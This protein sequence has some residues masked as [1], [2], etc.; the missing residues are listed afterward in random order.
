MSIDYEK[1]NKYLTLVRDAEI[2][3]SSHEE[4][5]DSEKL[6]EF[7][8]I[9]SVLEQNI[10]IAKSDSRK[11]S[12]GIV[13]AVKAGKSSFLNAC[14][15]AGEDYLPKAATPMTAA[16]TRITYSETPKAI[17]HFYTKEDWETIERHSFLYDEVLDADYNA[18]CQH[19]Y[20]QNMQ[21]SQCGKVTCSQ[22]MSKQEYEVGFK[23][24]SENQRGAKELTK[25]VQDS[26]LLEKLGTTDEIEGNIIQKLNDY[27]GANGHYTPIVSY[28]ELQVDNPYVKDFEI[29]D[30]PGL[31]D[32][33]V[34]RGIRT[35][36]FLRSCDVVLL[37]SPCSQFM[38]SRT[39]TLMASSLPSAGVRE[40]LVVGSKLDSGILN[41]N[42][43]DFAVAY[44][45]S[46]ASYKS[47]F[48]KNLE[49]AKNIGK[50]IDILGKM[51]AE[52]VLFASSSC[53][54]I[55][56]KMKASVALDDNEHTVYD[57]LHKRFSNF[58]DDYFA[59]LGGIKKVKEKLNE[60]LSRKK[61]IIEGKNSDLLDNARINHLR[62]LEKILQET[63]SSRTK[64]ETTSA[65]ELKHKSS[66]IRDIIDSSRDKLIHIFDNAV[67]KCDEKVQQILPQLTAE[68]G[69]HKRL[70]VK[71]TTRDE[72]KTENVGLFGWK[73]EIVHFTVTDNIADISSVVE[74]I[75]MYSAKCHS[76]V[77]SEFKNIFNKEKFAQDIKN[78]VLKAF[79][80]SN[81]EF[82]E[83]DILLPLQNVLD[84][85][86]IH[87]IT[88]DYTPYI[89]EIETRFKTGYAKN[90][91]IPQLT[92]LQS[93][94][95]N[96]IEVDISTQLLHELKEI[97][98]TL[99][100]Q[101]VFFA[102][103][104]ENEFCSEL[105]K[106]QGQVEEREKYIKEYLKFAETIKDLKVKM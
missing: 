106:L 4:L 85:I 53:F 17:I 62:V 60:V 37:L 34:S 9:T 92:I 105:E 63:V 87:H 56:K 8:Q 90:E 31:N 19:I 82:D 21:V 30:T 3:L 11:L 80:R 29:V 38:D 47:Q 66:N 44:K 59:S 1:A 49:Q 86:S 42:D 40:I 95:L 7:K 94:L 78:V 50:H 36:Q 2:M 100:T 103:Q 5:F 79:S 43:N 73:K 52:T 13:G 58:K 83:D 67:I 89:D 98:K 25:M 71:K 46:L 70:T 69:Q 88:F 55:D 75:E 68:K 26:T 27:V 65:D 76:F 12:I 93:R 33:I 91:E 96:D 15:F 48:K 18:Y 57:N 23:C 61:E 102:D 6:I 54:A 28:V 81:K 74:N 14:I 97:K 32:P 99:E 20:N 64:L 72:H 41:E 45:K 77:N 51:S 104:I 16:L 84:K 39:V 35:K 10:E 24:K 22:P 101:A